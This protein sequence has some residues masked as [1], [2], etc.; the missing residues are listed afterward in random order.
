MARWISRLALVLGLAGCEPE[1]VVDFPCD[2]EGS[3]PGPLRC[4]P[5][6]HVCITGESCE[7]PRVECNGRCIDLSASSANCGDCG[8]ACAASERCVSGVCQTDP[9]ETE[10]FCLPGLECVAGKC[11][12]GGRGSL[13][14]D[15]LC[16]DLQQSSVS[17]GACLN[18]CTTSG[19]QCR[20][21]VCTCPPGEKECGD[22]CV[23]VSANPSHC[24]TCGNA[25]GSG[26]KCERGVCV[27]ACTVN[28]N[29]ACGDG[30]CWDLEADPK[31][32]GS[33]CRSC[34]SLE[35]CTAGACACPAG[36][37]TCNGRCTVLESDP[38]N[39]GACGTRCAL[40]EAC[41]A[42]ACGCQGGLTR[43]G[44]ECVSLV[45][46]TNCGACGQACGAGLSCSQGKCV[47]ACSL[48]A[49]RCD[50]GLCADTGND[51]RNCGSCGQACQA[52]EV[53]VDGHCAAQTSAVGCT[54][55]PCDACTFDAEA[56]CCLRSGAPYCVKAERCPR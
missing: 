52:S 12:C 29:N 38:E 45:S 50:T 55:C 51:P 27:A 48:T 42:G 37:T 35:T 44:N 2:L 53:C 5:D 10:C 7:A 23:D 14:N 46:Q 32:C 6:A 31:H 54:S 34:R 39:C 40:G 41:V 3:C 22:A 15:V 20:A 26:Q 47:A 49:M 9:V 43:C 1:S 17:C 28:T 18:F 24:G 19:S 4:D 16:F 56:L 8:R 25:C 36:S 13:C 21:G 33:T 11:S 30:K